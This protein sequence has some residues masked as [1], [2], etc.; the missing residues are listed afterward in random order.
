MARF[1]GNCGASLPD[2]ARVC[3]KCG[4]PLKDLSSE[5]KDSAGFGEKQ[6]SEKTFTEPQGH[7]SLGKKASSE[8]KN[9]PEG[10]DFSEKKKSAE[11]RNSPVKRSSSENKGQ[12]PLLKKIIPIVVAAAAFLI[13]IFLVSRLFGGSGYEKAV[14]NFWK[15]LADSDGK[16]MSEVVSAASFEDDY[17]LTDFSDDIIDAYENYDGREISCEIRNPE[18]IQGEKLEDFKKQ[19]FYKLENRDTD[20]D[21]ESISEAMEID[22][23]VTFSDEADKNA[24]TFKNTLLVKENGEWKI[25]DPLGLLDFNPLKRKRYNEALIS[26]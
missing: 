20:Y 5:G 25:L 9:S 4:V 16:L 2:D 8:N 17:E 3:G 7:V 6:D 22:M 11:R 10:R 26:K 23:R 19:L 1:C 15:A 14:Q 21:V 24:I 13:V 12:N 18:E